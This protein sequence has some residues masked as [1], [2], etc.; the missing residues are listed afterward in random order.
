[1]S[2]GDLFETDEESFDFGEQNEYNGSN[3]KHD[4]VG[5]LLDLPNNV[6]DQ[7]TNLPVDG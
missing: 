5:L 7:S 3:S 4:E 6:L 2:V 1:L